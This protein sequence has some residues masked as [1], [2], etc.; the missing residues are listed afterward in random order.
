MVL[1]TMGQDNR[2][3]H[4]AI[5]QKIADIR[6]NQIYPQHIFLG[7]HETGVNHQNFI[8]HPDNGHVLTDFP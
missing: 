4:V 3:N 8:I 6:D 1:M 7:E 5:F 2:F